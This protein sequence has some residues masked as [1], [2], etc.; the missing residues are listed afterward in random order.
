[1]IARMSKRINIATLLPPLVRKF[2]YAPTITS[3]YPA[4][5]VNCRG[6]SE[7]RATG[8]ASGKNASKV[9]ELFILGFNRDLSTVGHGVARI[10][11]Q[12]HHHLFNLPT[13]SINIRKLLAGHERHIY[14]FTNQPGQHP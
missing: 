3:R 6:Y 13:V 7:A 11:N 8:T 1:M 9:I 10:H 2:L 4:W 14:V 12:V 5:G